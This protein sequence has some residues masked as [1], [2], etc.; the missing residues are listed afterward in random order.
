MNVVMKTPREESFFTDVPF[1]WNPF[2][3]SNQKIRLH[4]LPAS[5]YFRNS[6]S[7]EYCDEVPYEQA[8]IYRGE[9]N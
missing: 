1:Y 9:P 6:S 3:A 5:L 8:P 4:D 2:M 7:K